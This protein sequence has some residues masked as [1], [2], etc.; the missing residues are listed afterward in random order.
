MAIAAAPTHRLP[1]A[2][3]PNALNALLWATQTLAALVVGRAGLMMLTMPAPELAAR[4][5]AWVTAIPA[6]SVHAL[7]ALVLA[8]AL[9]LVAPSFVRI[10]PSLTGVAAAALAAVLAL[11]AAVHGFR[12]EVGPLLVDLALVAML[13]F[14]G[15][16]RT[17]KSPIEPH[18]RIR[19]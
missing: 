12:G 3:G 8:G 1:R 10:A 16:G 6:S 2:L 15:W 5:G 11:A 7:G 17:F 14:I 18:A 9:G 19:C 13:V 4:L